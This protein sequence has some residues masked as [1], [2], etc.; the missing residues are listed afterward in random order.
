VTQPPVPEWVVQVPATAAVTNRNALAFAAP[1][2]NNL[3]QAQLNSLRNNLLESIWQ[4]LVQWFTGGLL[5]GPA[6]PQLQNFAA[7]LTGAL[8]TYLPVSTF[9]F[10]I[11]A[12]AGALG[13]TAPPGTVYS[14]TDIESFL[15]IIPPVNVQGTLGQ[16]TLQQDLTQWAT[17]LYGAPAVQAITT[18]EQDIAH[19]LT[20]AITGGNAPTS[21]N[22]PVGFLQQLFNYIPHTNVVIPPN[23]GTG[24]ILHDSTTFTASPFTGPVTSL[25]GWGTTHLC[26][27]NANYIVMRL[28]FYSTYTP[29][30]LATYH[31]IAMS[32]LV[33]CV[34]PDGNTYSIIYGLPNP[35]T[36]S[37]YNANA[38]FYSP[39]GSSIYCITLEVDSYIGVG[40]VNVVAN[41]SSAANNPAVTIGSASGHYSICSILTE[42]NSIGET[43]TDT[44][45]TGR[46]VEYNS[47]DIPFSGVF[48]TA[49]HM[50]ALGMDSA[51]GTSTVSFAATAAF[52]SGAEWA[53]CAVDFVPALSTVLG[54]VF[55]AAN[56][57]TSNV[58]APAANTNELFPNSFFNTVQSGMPSND[59]TYNPTNNNAVIITMAGSYTI[60]IAVNI[61]ATVSNQYAQLLL[62][63]TPSGGGAF[64][65][66]GDTKYIYN[67]LA[68][69]NYVISHTFQIYC[70]AG[71]T[72]QPGYY[73]STTGNWFA[74][75]SNGDS[76][77]FE[78]SLHNRGLL[79]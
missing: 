39:L 42:S 50:T 51:A 16:P 24:T 15:G 28:S 38:N 69:A 30:V 48:G 2:W 4:V 67:P 19:F 53:A 66:R 71:D 75:T 35:P 62:A 9:Q 10:L 33:Q 55:R 13:H 57:S 34:A 61:S 52:P 59:L 79:S 65:K 43:L 29:I 27:T 77:Y 64:V 12:I 22:S 32:P 73:V 47:G 70:A 31:S 49:A 5:P 56:T 7:G 37:S 78:V 26:A 3:D 17:Q 6:G 41:N 54:S 76:T 40:A 60:T 8:N 58:S 11:T 18:V 74:G 36:G 63:Q 45:P 46:V 1:A 44:A 14:W 25:I 68:S 72:L 20:N 21:T 23:P